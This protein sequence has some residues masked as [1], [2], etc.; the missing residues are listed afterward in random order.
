MGL[1][2]CCFNDKRIPKIKNPNIKIIA[3]NMYKSVDISIFSIL[4]NKSE[5]V[6][7]S[8]NKEK[9]TRKPIISVK[10]IKIKTNSFDPRPIL[11]IN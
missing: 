7:L 4:V 10:N 9:V 1:N 3:N 8:D 11:S 5:G 2:K 6:I